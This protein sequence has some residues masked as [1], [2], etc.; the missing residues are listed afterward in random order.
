MSDKKTG[1]SPLK[2][3]NNRGA[4]NDVMFAYVHTKKKN[5]LSVLSIFS[6]L[7]YDI[8]LNTQCFVYLEF[9]RCP[10]GLHRVSGSR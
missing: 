7:F 2:A 1:Y 9:I 6:F 8:N 3:E 10:L 4:I 5:L